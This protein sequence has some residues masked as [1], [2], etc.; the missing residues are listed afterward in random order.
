MKT[1]DVKAKAERRSI[2]TRST[3]LVWAGAAIVACATV[4][5]PIEP[6]RFHRTAAVEGANELMGADECST[7]HD[8]VLG[9]APIPAYHADCESCHGAG[10]MHVD[11]EEIADIRYPSSSECLECHESGHTTALAW[12]TG[13][14]ERAGVICADCHNPHNREPQNVRS[15]ARMNFPNADANSQLCISCH[16][17]VAAQLHLPSHHPVRE[18]MVGCTDCHAPHGDRRT[19]LGGGTALC[20]SCHQ[21][22]AGPW[23]FE[24]SP[25]SETCTG[26]HAPH[27]AASYNL[28]DTSQPALC[29]SCHSSPDTWHIR[30]GEPLG[31]G[32]PIT[33]AVSQAFYTRCTDCHGAIHGSYED[34]YLRR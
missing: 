21:D 31:P 19:A 18:G 30:T 4:S 5:V 17:E 14:H 12:G 22:H 23:I 16:A 7:C 9:R 15:V 26:C 24:H 28:L 1:C 2:R 8:E 27:G 11:S 13:E 33:T 20:S 10:N 32:D 34:P 3:L 25:V 29:L 6:Q